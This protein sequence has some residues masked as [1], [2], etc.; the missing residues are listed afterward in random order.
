MI[1]CAI[2]PSAFLQ[3]TKSIAREMYPGLVMQSQAV[4]AL[5]QACEAFM[6]DLFSDASMS[7]CLSNRVRVTERDIF[8]AL[9][10]KGN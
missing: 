7:A 5:Q 6:S 3:L 1:D 4:L 8:L 2:E 9:R 10:M